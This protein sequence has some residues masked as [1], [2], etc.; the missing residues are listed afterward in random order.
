M[1]AN[2][3]EPNEMVKG[4]AEVYPQVSP[5]GQYVAYLFSD[6]DTKRPRINVIRFDDGQVIKTFDLP[7]SAT[8]NYAESLNYRGFH[9]SPDGKGVVYIDTIAGVSNLWRASLEGGPAKKITDFKADRIYRFAYASDGRTLAVS[10]GS[11]TPDAVLI[12]ST[13]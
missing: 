13:K 9:W 7:V 5:D 4:G 8:T 3:G 1:P 12:K 10:R 2:G 6:P 11:E